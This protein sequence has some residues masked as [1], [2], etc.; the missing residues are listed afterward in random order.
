MNLTKRQIKEIIDQELYEYVQETFP[1][2][3]LSED[4]MKHLKKAGSGLIDYYK[5]MAKNYAKS[6]DAMVNKGILPAAKAQSDALDL[7]LDPREFAQADDEEKLAAMDDMQQKM[8]SA[9]SYAKVSPEYME[10][11]KQMIDAAKKV[12]DAAEAKM[13]GSAEDSESASKGS[14]F[15]DELL[16]I[17][18]PVADEWDK[19]QKLTKDPKLKNAMSYIEQVALS[20]SVANRIVEKILKELKR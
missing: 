5:I 19:I 17:L 2:G 7:E 20:E 12:D 18:D 4:F 1:N 11:I 16:D 3:E 9:S 8:K 15:S 10:K 6:M 13:G 14:Q